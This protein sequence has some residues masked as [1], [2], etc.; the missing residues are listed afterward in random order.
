[1]MFWFL[2][3]LMT[4]AACMSVIAPFLRPAGAAVP[5]QAHNLEVYADQLREVERDLARG[6]IGRGEADEARAELGRRIL[7]IADEK[8]ASASVSRKSRV[9]ATL[10]LLMVPILGWGVYGFVGSPGLPG[11]P[12]QARLA[13]DP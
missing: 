7:R 12:L 3:A 5:S 2:A 1:M 9:V 13:K 10:A 8:R 6:L 4:F 11:E